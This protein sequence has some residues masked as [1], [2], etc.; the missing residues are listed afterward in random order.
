[1][2]FTSVIILIL[3]NFPC[4]LLRLQFYLTTVETFDFELCASFLLKK[5]LLMR[6][7][8]R[9]KQPIKVSLQTYLENFCENF[10]LKCFQ[11][12]LTLSFYRFVHFNRFSC[13]KICQIC[14]TLLPMKQNL[15]LNPPIF[16]TLLISGHLFQLFLISNMIMMNFF[17]KR[18]CSRI[19]TMGVRG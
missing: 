16:L 9:M 12:N 14:D 7:A 10:A 6:K 13:F 17:L 15:L 1:M 18:C 2:S 3:H 4:F 19:V 5:A 8:L 11:L